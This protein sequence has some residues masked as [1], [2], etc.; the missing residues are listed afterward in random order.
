MIRCNFSTNSWSKN[1]EILEI[2]IVELNNNNNNKPKPKNRSNYNLCQ[3][4]CLMVC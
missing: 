3:C 4:R 2:L 1:N